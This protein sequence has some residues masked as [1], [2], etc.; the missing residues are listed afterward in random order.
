MT[1]APSTKPRKRVFYLDLVR[2]LAAVLVVITHFNNPYLHQAQK[3]HVFAYEPFGIYIGNL[4]VSLFL[5]ISGAALMMTYGGPRLDL[6]V[7]YWKR[8]KGIYPMFWT[9][10]IL[11]TLYFFLANQGVARN[12]APTRAFLFT[13]FGMDGMVANFHIQTM[14]LLGE[15]FLGFIVLFYIVF[16]LLRWAVMTY[17]KTT[18][19]AIFVIYAVTFVLLNEI[20]HSFPN[21]I[22]LPLRLPEL[23]FGM[24]FVRYVHRLPT[25]AILP[26]VLPCACVLII[27]ARR[28]L[29]NED[30]ATPFV[31]VAC[32][33]ILA[34]AARY[35]D[36]GP[37]REPVAL[38][39]KYSYPIFLVHHVVIMK[40]FE[41]TD[42]RAFSTLQLY[43]LFAAMS[44]IVFGLSVGLHRLNA[45]VVAFFTRAFDGVT[46]LPRR[47]KAP[48]ET[49]PAKDQTLS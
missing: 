26:W 13:L 17:P 36:V 2:A 10:W 5:I 40:I 1:A 42:T 3:R 34:M 48:E 18:A 9:A 22:V 49:P 29:L 8:F 16:P 30:F 44:I 14:Y 24:Y 20:P 6:R 27:S 4:G 31:G 28:P 33:F 11:G 38:I 39:A 12:H 37:V 47:R 46:L 45:N 23:A 15:W 32:F 21:L 7:F 25:W 41:S 19:A 43:M 35:L